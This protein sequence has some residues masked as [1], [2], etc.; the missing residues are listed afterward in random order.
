MPCYVFKTEKN[1]E[2]ENCLK[3]IG[4]MKVAT[5]LAL[6]LIRL[7]SCTLDHSSNSSHPSIPACTRTQDRQLLEQLN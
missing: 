4:E 5:E 2:E 1:T 3:A 6:A 7:G